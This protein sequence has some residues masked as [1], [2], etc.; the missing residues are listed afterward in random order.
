M[1]TLS[2]TLSSYTRDTVALASNIGVQ[3]LISL[4]FGLLFFKGGTSYYSLSTATTQDIQE[5]QSRLGL[6]F[7]FI[8]G[9]WHTTIL[10]AAMFHNKSI[11]FFREV[12]SGYYT[13]GPYFLSKFICEMLPNR[14]VPIILYSCVTY[15]MGGLWKSAEVFV[16]WLLPLLTMAMCSGSILLLYCSIFSTI[17]IVCQSFVLTTLLMLFTMGLTP[18]LNQLPVVI[19]WMQYISI[20]RY[21]LVNHVI[22]EFLNLPDGMQ[23][24]VTVLTTQ[25]RIEVIGK[26]FEIP[27]EDFHYGTY[28]RN[29][30]I[31]WAIT[32]VAIL[33]TYLILKLKT[34]RL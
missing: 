10:S 18:S 6:I 25:E 14:L 19:R 1:F 11:L 30:G 23:D 9:I 7:G 33:G 27:I 12:K 21:T 26:L 17:Q 34:N 8:F 2:T 16:L 13:A 32:I 31:V 4:A 22:N 24:N 5:Q 29:Y 20:P 28:W 3:I 15:W